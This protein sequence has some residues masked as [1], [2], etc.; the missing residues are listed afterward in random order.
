MAGTS[1]IVGASSGIGAALARQYALEEGRSVAILARRAAE[2][3]ALRAEIEA[4][5]G[6]VLAL[7]HDVR[8]FSAVPQLWERIEAELGEADLLVQAAGVLPREESPENDRLTVEVG[9]VGAIGWLDEA[10]ARFGARGKGAIVGISSIAGDRGRQAFP[11]YHA[12]KAG[13][14]TFLESLHYRL[15]RKGVSVTTIKPGFIDTAMTRGKTGLFW[16]ITPDQAARTIRR[17]VA[18][19]RRQAYVPARWALVSF[20]VRAVPAFLMRRMRF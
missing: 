12:A 13:L 7:V 5:G 2:L 6:R 3:E 4:A 11:A 18:A 10:A 17:K 8:D 15:H 14:S 16:L 19:R 20:V 1:I 9:L